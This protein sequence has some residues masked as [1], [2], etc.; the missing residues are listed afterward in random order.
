MLEDFIDTAGNM[1][2]EGAGRAA[3]GARQGAKR[4][5]PGVG[6][7]IDDQT[8]RRIDDGVRGEEWLYSAR[9]KPN[10]IPNS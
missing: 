7:G 6:L 3:Q 9:H 4:A 8:L 10:F 2:V 5:I 1:A